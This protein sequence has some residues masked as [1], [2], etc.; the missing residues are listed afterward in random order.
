MDEPLSN[1]DAKLRV[2]MREE[3]H[4][5][6]RQLGTTTIYVTHDQEEALVISDSIAVM[7]FGVIQQVGTAWEIY[8]EPVNTFVASFVG[9]M[10]FID[11]KV[12]A[13]DNGFIEVAVNR[14]TVKTSQP[15]TPVKAIR[16][17][18]RPEDLSIIPDRASGEE[19]S[20][21]PGTVEKTTFTGSLVQY[22]VDCGA[23]LQLMVERHKPEHD[24]LIPTGSS[25]FV[26]IPVHALL[27]FH[28]DT[29]ER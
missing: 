29:G 14:H 2:E 17:A 22:T 23:D 3:I 5:I 7:N 27:L 18:V 15:E 21:I 6:Q 12:A 20:S 16:L 11:G 19:F 4:D 24:A 1:L 10:N 13:S 25:I 8:K 26:K 9:N 28:P